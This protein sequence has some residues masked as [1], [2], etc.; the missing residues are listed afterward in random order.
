[1]K[2]ETHAAA[3]KESLDEIRDCIAKGVESRQRTIG[4]HCS[5]AAADLLEIYLH[6]QNLIDAGT[7]I[8]H[9]W[10]SSVKTASKRLPDF[11]QKTEILQSLNEIEKK[12]NLLCYG[13]PQP[14]KT[15]EELIS[16]FNKLKAKLE[17]LGV[18]I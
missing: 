1:M 15:I 5:A 2:T 14:A 7:S 9:N 8:K 13:K 6:Q 3:V 17:N 11:P 4:F 18:K 10:F 12:R 16:T